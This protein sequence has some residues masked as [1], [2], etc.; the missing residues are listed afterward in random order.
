MLSPEEIR[1][2]KGKYCSLK[3]G[4]SM[5][6]ANRICIEFGWSSEICPFRSVRM[7]YL[8][9]PYLFLGEASSGLQCRSRK[10]YD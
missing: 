8:R 10:A 6:D 4:S 5:A 2:E 1:R 7:R 3:L 9:V